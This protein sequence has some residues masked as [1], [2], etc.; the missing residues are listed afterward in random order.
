MRRDLVYNEHVCFA[1]T[2]DSVTVTT[3]SIYV[4]VSC[5]GS[6]TYFAEPAVFEP[7]Q[8]FALNDAS[9]K[10][11]WDPFVSTAPSICIPILY[12]ISE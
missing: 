4:S 12:V 5:S 10:F 6:D 11:S 1:C 8:I 9:A 7:T 2:D 3:N